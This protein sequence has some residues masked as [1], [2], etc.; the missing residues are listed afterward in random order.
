[1]RATG[2]GRNEKRANP[3]SLLLFNFDV[4]GDR[5]KPEH[6]TFLRLEALPTL[7]A[8][9]SVRVIG[10][11]DRTGSRSHNQNLS[12]RRAART[13]EFLR[14][15]IGPSLNLRQESGFGE[16]AAKREGEKDG[17]SDDRF[18]SVLVFLSPTV[19]NN[20]VFEIAAKSFIAL[21]GKST[22]SMPGIKLVPN[23]AMQPPLIPVPRQV[24]LDA[25]ALATDANFH[26][27]P[28]TVAKDKRY[29]LFSSCRITVI[30]ENNQILA[31]VPSTLDTDVGMEGPFQPPD[32]TTSPVFVS[33]KGSNFVTFSWTGKGRPNLLV[34]P[35]FQEVR[36][37]TSVFI[38]H[39]VS[40]RIDVS[41]GTPSVTVAIEGSHF[42]SHRAFLNGL[43]IHPD[44]RQ[45]PFTDLWV[46][47]PADSTKVK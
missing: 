29:R 47:D 2:P 6:M 7:R 39:T 41:S 38:W 3:P 11:T 40:G 35:T 42:P 9:G 26:E 34:E 1:M 44:L 27:N 46:P 8:S 4:D 30:W 43:P 22:G 19:T 23:P 28:L 36:S 45:G 24:L 10:L 31:A 21:I 17:T 20:K 33:P 32:M 15:E 18:R 14:Q 25:L 13:V 37:R 5:L 12:E 16:D